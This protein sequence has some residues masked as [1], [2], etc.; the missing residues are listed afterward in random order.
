MADLASTI[1]DSRRPTERPIGG[2]ARVDDPAPQ[3][4]PVERRQGPASTVAWGVHQRSLRLT[5]PEQAPDGV[6]PARFQ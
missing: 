3:W 1:L 4:S 6:R 5:A 2:P